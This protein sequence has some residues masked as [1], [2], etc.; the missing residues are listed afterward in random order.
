[1]SSKQLVKTDSAEDSTL[2]SCASTVQLSPGSSMSSVNTDE[3]DDNLFTT[4]S[5]QSLDMNMNMNTEDLQE[6]SQY[7]TI[8]DQDKQKKRAPKKNSDSSTTSKKNMERQSSSSS[9]HSNKSSS[10]SSSS[11]KK[12]FWNAFINTAKA[13]STSNSL[14][15]NSTAGLVDEF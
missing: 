3:D 7:S 15:I 13:C 8:H 14:N 11:K 9:I 4:Q 10:S 5:L 12:S 1:M 6:C 2:S